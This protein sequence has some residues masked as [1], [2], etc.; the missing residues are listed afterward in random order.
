MPVKNYY[1]RNGQIEFE[2]V[3]SNV[4][5]YGR[6]ML[7]NVVAGYDNATNA[8]F[9]ANYKPYGEFAQTTGNISGQRFMY[10]GTHGYRFSPSVPVSHYVR[11]RHLL[12]RMGMWTSVDPLWPGQPSL[13]YADANPSS[14]YDF[15]GMRPELPCAGQ[16][17]HSALAGRHHKRRFIGPPQ[18]VSEPFTG[19]DVYDI[20]AE[21]LGIEPPPRSPASPTCKLVTCEALTDVW[22]VLP[23]AG[24]VAY[25]VV[26][27]GDLGCSV[28]YYHWGQPRHWPKPQKNGLSTDYDSLASFLEAQR[29]AAD[30]KGRCVECHEEWIP[31]DFAYLM[32]ECNSQV[33]SADIAHWRKWL[34]TFTC[35][36]SANF[37]T[38]CANVNNFFASIF[39]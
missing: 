30:G 32:C 12:M 29:S 4:I 16:G 11:A 15:W 35:Y 33:K 24:H 14:T 6:D 10:C 20:L 5:T 39:E 36:N 31:C 23:I 9:T 28:D 13:R 34:G 38:L 7:G 19:K 3:G 8:V 37:M 27:H 1:S 26:V 22:G 18:T 21:K 17:L 2:A 25:F